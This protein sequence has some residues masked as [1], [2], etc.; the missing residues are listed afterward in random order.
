MC[1][2]QWILYYCTLLTPIMR[3]GFDLLLFVNLA[4]CELE[5]SSCNIAQSPSNSSQM[6]NNYDWGQSSVNSMSC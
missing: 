4:F 1:A 2:M 5:K 6:S 3:S